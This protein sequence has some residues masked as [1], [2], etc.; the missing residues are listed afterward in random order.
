MF[1]VSREAEDA[2]RAAYEERGEWSAVVELRRYY[3]GITDNQA[4]RNAVR[5]IAGWPQAEQKDQCQ[6]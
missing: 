6:D 5:M 4:A 2:I 3:P 1:L